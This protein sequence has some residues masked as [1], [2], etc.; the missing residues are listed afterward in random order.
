MS[1]GDVWHVR[2]QPVLFYPPLVWRVPSWHL[3]VGAASP[4]WTML[5]PS[6]HISSQPVQ[7]KISFATLC[8]K[9]QY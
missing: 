6:C 7:P 8:I 4:E 3:A 2:Y 5:Y 1:E 9:L